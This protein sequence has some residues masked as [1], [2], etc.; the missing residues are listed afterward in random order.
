MA[1][2]FGLVRVPKVG[3][4]PVLNLPAGAS[5]SGPGSLKRVQRAAD[6]GDGPVAYF[7]VLSNTVDEWEAF[8]AGPQ[9]GLQWLAS[10][11][12]G[13]PGALVIEITAEFVRDN[14]PALETAGIP[15]ELD[16]RMR[17]FHTICGQSAYLAPA[18]P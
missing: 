6:T 11:L 7:Y 16:G 17:A 8:F 5:L 1:N 15:F 13:E 4:E 3:G 18:D 9:A 10:A 12:S 14:R 2:V